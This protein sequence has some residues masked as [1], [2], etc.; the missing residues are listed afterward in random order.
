M[1]DRLGRVAIVG[2][3]QVGT[4][5]G[6][7][8]R[9]AGTEVVLS[10][11]R[12]GAVRESIARGGG[13]GEVS[14]DEACNADSIVLAVPVP[15]IVRLIPEIGP[16]LSPG[17]FVVD[18]G[19]AKRVVVDAMRENFSTEVHAIGGHPLAGSERRGAEGASPDILEGAVFALAPVRDDPE[20]ESRGRALAEAVG[21][22]P[23]VIDAELHDRVVATTSHAPHLLAAAVALASR[24]LP[25]DS[26]RYLAASGFAGATRL[27]AS[28]AGMVSGFLAANA[29]AVRDALKAVRAAL[30]RAEASLEDADAL[31]VLFAEASAARE[32]ALG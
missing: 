14:L 19:S 26:V 24:E 28:D 7:A 1:T 9:A 22:R 29:D 17:S 5:L 23:V 18:T 8:L 6:V 30:D 2:A 20:A 31:R 12:P 16:K 4:M 32:D 11:R 27:A 3:G 13:D 21:S 25:N 10:D 15:E